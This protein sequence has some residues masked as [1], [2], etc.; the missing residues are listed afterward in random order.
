MLKNDCTYCR[1]DEHKRLKQLLLEDAKRESEEIEK[2]RLLYLE[3]KK[4]LDQ[5]HRDRCKQ[6]NRDNLT[7]VTEINRIRDIIKKQEMVIILEALID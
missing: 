1:I 2:L 5:M 7:H 3:E 4:N 6:L